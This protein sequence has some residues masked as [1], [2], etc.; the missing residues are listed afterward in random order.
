MENLYRNFKQELG[1]INATNQYI[2]MASRYFA[3]EHRKELEVEGGIKQMAEKVGLSVSVLPDNFEQRISRNYV[4]NIH[5]CLENFLKNFK[6]MPGT[7]TYKEVYDPN[8]D[9]YLSWTIK[10][11]FGS[12]PPNIKSLYYV[13]DYY[14]LARNNIIHSGKTEV[15]GEIKGAYNNACKIHE[16]YLESG[17]SERLNAPNEIGNLTFDDQVLFARVARCVV[18]QIVYN[19]HYN[20]YEIVDNDFENIYAISKKFKN[21]PSS[22]RRVVETYLKQYYVV[23][24]VDELMW[25]G[26]IQKISEFSKDNK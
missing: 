11:V 20:L 2:E 18:E 13:C 9:N 16:Q 5:S 26:V 12:I 15:V 4:I 6:N 1:Y 24:N 25:K 8:I 22:M 14:R 19:S 21:N 10:K 23:L 17:L 7:P 3:E